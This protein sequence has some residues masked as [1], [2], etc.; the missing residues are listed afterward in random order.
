MDTVVLR[1]QPVWKFDRRRREEDLLHEFMAFTVE[2]S[3]RGRIYLS[4][5]SSKV[6]IGKSFLNNQL[7]FAQYA[8][9]RRVSRIS[10]LTV[11]EIDV[12]KIQRCSGNQ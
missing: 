6:V 7:H 9:L 8:G 3:R 11:G 1:V 10:V 12:G 4:A 2:Q 5:N